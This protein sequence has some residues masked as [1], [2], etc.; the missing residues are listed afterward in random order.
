MHLEEQMKHIFQALEEQPFKTV[1]KDAQMDSK[2][3]METTLSIVQ[4]LTTPILVEGSDHNL[5]IEEETLFTDLDDEDSYEFNILIFGDFS[6]LELRKSLDYD[7][8]DEIVKE[9]PS[10]EELKIEGESQVMVLENILVKIDT[11]SFSIDIVIWGSEEE[12]K[13]LKILREPLPSSSQALIDTEKG[14]H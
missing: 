4:E 3:C 9:S 14:K 12:L 7:I 5:E 1:P 8:E 6:N 13:A 2:E 11:F 10:L